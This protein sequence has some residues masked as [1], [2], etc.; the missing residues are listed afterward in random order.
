MKD[1]DQEN[2]MKENEIEVPHL[3]GF[4]L[5]S[6]EKPDRDYIPKDLEYGILQD[7]VTSDIYAKIKSSPST[8]NE[9][10]HANGC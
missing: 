5:M 4:R 9:I 7:W 2:T 6:Q 10:A 3:R 1:L 8:T